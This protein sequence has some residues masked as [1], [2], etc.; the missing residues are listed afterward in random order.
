MLDLPCRIRRC[1]STRKTAVE[2][3]AFPPV[4]THTQGFGCHVVSPRTARQLPPHAFVKHRRQHESNRFLGPSPRIATG[5]RSGSALSGDDMKSRWHRQM[6]TDWNDLARHN[7]PYYILTAPELTDPAHFDEQQFFESGRRDVDSMLSVLHV[8]LKKEWSVL[9]IGCGLGRLTRR[10][11]ELYGKATG[12]DVSGEMI[13]R[14]RQLNPH[15]VFR[16]V[17]GTD[18]NSFANEAFDLVLSF[19]VFQHFPKSRLVFQYL[20]EI[21]RILRPEG[22][23]LIQANTSYCPAFKRAYWNLLRR[24]HADSNRDR[25]SF[26]GSCLGVGRIERYALMN[27]LMTDIVLYQG[28][29]WTYFRFS[30]RAPEALFRGQRHAYEPRPELR[31]LLSPSHESV[32]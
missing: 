29:P 18:L 24:G 23:A 21:S 16:E 20:R 31:S 15:I 1:P 32:D 5:F 19:I 17:S 9:D 25:A 8:P 13:H 6:K 26:R 4:L 30:K 7:A 12:V 11:S 14:A 3:V 22:L 10:L 27:G 2:R 28:T